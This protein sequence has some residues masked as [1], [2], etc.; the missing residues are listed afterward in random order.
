LAAESNSGR[1]FADGLRKKSHG[2]SSFKA[3]LTILVPSCAIFCAP[4]EGTNIEE[5]DSCGS[6]WID[7]SGRGFGAMVFR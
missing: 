1:K 6:N 7:P 4:Q 5:N 2:S 3:S